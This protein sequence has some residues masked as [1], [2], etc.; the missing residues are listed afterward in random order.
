[1]PELKPSVVTLLTTTHRS[2][3]QLYEAL[4]GT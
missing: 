1:M 3:R 4:Q 2:C